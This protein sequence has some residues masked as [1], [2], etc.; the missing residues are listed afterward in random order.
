MMLIFNV[1]EILLKVVVN[2]INQTINVST[3]SNEKKRKRFHDQIL[4]ISAK[5]WLSGS[6]FI[7]VLSLWIL[8]W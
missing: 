4:I 2:T 8:I 7:Y 6:I 5:F 3:K 1:I